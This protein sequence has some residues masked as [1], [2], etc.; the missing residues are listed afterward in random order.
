MLI[1][2]DV[3]LQRGINAFE[4]TLKH[5]QRAKASAKHLRKA[6]KRITRRAL[7]AAFDQWITV[8]ET[9]AQVCTARDKGIKRMTEQALSAAL[10]QWNTV[11]DTKL[12]ECTARDKGT[13]FSFGLIM[14][15]AFR[16]LRRLQCIGGLRKAREVSAYQMHLDQQQHCALAVWRAVA[17]CSL[18]KAREVSAYQNRLTQ[19]Q[20]CALA[21]WRAVTVSQQT[22]VDE[23]QLQVQCAQAIVRSSV[24]V[25]AAAFS[26]WR[27][28]TQY[29]WQREDR[30]RLGRRL[31]RRFPLF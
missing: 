26:S 1:A 16:H 12:R 31:W 13:W 4:S 19:Q 15:A 22:K 23:Q 20:R 21:V 2:L 10:D 18:R 8:L 29:T 3:H 5:Q 6:L 17:V 30:Q 9:S 11:V 14:T 25:A 28:S 7:G 24:K 27:V